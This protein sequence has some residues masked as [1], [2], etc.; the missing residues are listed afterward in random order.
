MSERLAAIQAAARSHPLVFFALDQLED[1]EDTFAP[2]DSLGPSLVE[3]LGTLDADSLLAAAL[4][5]FDLATVLQEKSN[6]FEAGEVILG[7]LEQV[8]SKLDAAADGL[9]GLARAL[10]PSRKKDDYGSAARAASVSL[11]GARGAHVG[12]AGFDLTASPKKKKR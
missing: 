7:A 4:G 6:A 9:P 3:K 12:N 10:K 2:R 11:E 1:D 5:L 8:S